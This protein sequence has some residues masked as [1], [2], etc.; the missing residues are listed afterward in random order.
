V[1]CAGPGLT[2][3]RQGRG[4]TYLEAD[5]TPVRDDELIERIRNLA[6]P[7]AWRDVWIC[8][9]RNGHLQAVGTDDAGRRQYLYHPAWREHRDREKFENMLAF[10]RRLPVVRK[11]VARLVRRDGLSR[12]RVLAGAVGLLDRGLFRVGGEEYAD[13]NGSYGLATLERRHVKLTDCAI[14]FDYEGKTGKRQTQEVVDPALLRVAG[15]LMQVRRRNPHFLAYREG[16]RFVD[17]RSDDINEFVKELAGNGFSAKDFRTWHATVLAAVSL[18]EAHSSEGRSQRKR[19]I[20]EAIRRTSDSLGNTPAVCRA[21]YIDPRVLDRFTAGNTIAETL[22]RI[23]WNPQGPPS[24]AQRNALERAVL[25]LL[26][27]D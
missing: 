20:V 6:I 2:R 4:F 19:A 1:D 8:P 13:E 11:S 3:R 21:S 16:R 24:V 15:E 23:R 22:G 25:D 27:S 14:V 17:V 7:P 26:A 12:E 5:G 9:H 18:A 10:G